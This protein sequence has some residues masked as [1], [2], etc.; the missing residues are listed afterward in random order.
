MGRRTK[1]WVMTHFPRGMLGHDTQ[2]SK[3]VGPCHV[4]WHSK[5]ALRPILQ[6]NYDPSLLNFFSIFLNLLIWKNV[7]YKISHFY[8]EFWKKIVISLHHICVF[9]YQS[10]LQPALVFMTTSL[11]DNYFSP[12]P[13]FEAGYFG[14][15]AGIISTM[16][17]SLTTSW[18][19]W[20]IQLVI[21]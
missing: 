9:M 17:L 7:Y 2:D 4:S 20:Y 14:Q 3:Y 5:N 16:L 1:C 19:F 21:T 10:P 11:F 15:R 18:S 12:L 6:V 13:G 8:T